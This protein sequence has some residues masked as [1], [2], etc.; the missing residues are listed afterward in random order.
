[1]QPTIELTSLRFPEFFQV[2]TI[3]EKL[4][5]TLTRYL[6]VLEDLSVVQK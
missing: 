2:L 6:M 1:M 4:P 3:P 5:E